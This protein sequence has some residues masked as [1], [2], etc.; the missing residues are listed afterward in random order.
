MTGA[1]HPTY[2]AAGRPAVRIA[3][4]EQSQ[5]S[6]A[7][8]EAPLAGAWRSKA[9]FKVAAP[10]LLVLAGLLFFTRLGSRALW[11]SEYRWA[12][13]AREMNVSSERFWPTM[14]GKVYYDKPLGSYWLVLGAAGLTGALDETSVRLPSACAALLALAVLLSLGR[15]LYGEQTAL[16][17]AAILASSLSFVFFARH[18][19]ADMETVAGE[20]V[21]LWLFVRLRERISAPGVILLWQAMALTSLTKGLLGFALPV[22]TMVVYSCLADG[23][24]ELR[25]GLCQGNLGRRWFWLR[26]RNRWFF[27]RYSLAALPLSAGVYLL[28]FVVSQLRTGSD[29]GLYMVYRENIL[30]FFRPFDHRGPVYL[31]F[32]VVFTLMAPWSAFVPAALARAHRVD[33]PAGAG[34]SGEDPL[35]L[36]YFWTTFIF[37][38]LSG[39]RRSY[40][41]LPILPAGALLVARLLTAGEETLTLLEKRLCRLGYL[42]LAA[43]TLSAIVAVLPPDW[44]PYRPLKL[45]PPL[46]ARGLFAVLWAAAGVSVLLALRRFELGMIRWSSA[47]I[48]WVI[49]AYVFVFAMPAGDAYRGEKPF[50]LETRRL[51]GSDVSS[52]AL[53]RALGPLFYLAMRRPIPYYDDPRVLDRAILSGGVRWVMTRQ[54]EAAHLGVPA[55]AVAWEASFPFEDAGQ[56]RNKLVLL[57]VG[58]PSLPPPR[59]AAPDNPKRR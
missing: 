38:T 48:A 3:R 21:V 12:E 42:C 55:R 35:A 51:I 15:K 19:S 4:V 29:A 14:N 43:L 44:R 54:G 27:N 6:Q 2:G 10:L 25:R 26:G 28:P 13:I 56:R 52:L 8:P 22:F 23:W 34:R 20:L 36:V 41:L 53:Y 49:M 57:A 17:A 9:G 45:L 18:A 39:S 31:Y 11:A 40:Y 30:R 7:R 47:F 1:A 32:Y 58:R 33:G 5:P 50:A 16:W 24:V 59:P 37:F 46:P